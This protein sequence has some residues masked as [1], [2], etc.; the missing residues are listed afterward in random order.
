MEMQTEMQAAALRQLLAE[1]SRAAQL[2]EKSEVGC[3]GI[4]LSQC[5]LLLA[6]SGREGEGG[7]SLSD[8]ALVLGL[9]LSTVSRVADGLVRQNL[10]KRDVDAKDRRRS[11]LFLT[12]EGRELVGGINRNMRAYTRQ[13]LEKIPP[14]ERTAVLRSLSLLVEAVKNVEGGCCNG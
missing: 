3:C 8:L 13:I 4:T 6:V 11:V 14:Q 2:L 10:L 12:E 1:L 7:I 5:H 9:D